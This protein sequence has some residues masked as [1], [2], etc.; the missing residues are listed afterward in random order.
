MTE[1]LSEQLAGLN[2]GDTFT[3]F[4]DEYEVSS[5]HFTDDPQL[6]ATDLNSGHDL[7][8]HFRHTGN[9]EGV[10]AI[11]EFRHDDSPGDDDG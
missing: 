5:R 11:E 8:I 4:G 10:V 6:Y 1:L 2:S 9:T 3:L 7:K